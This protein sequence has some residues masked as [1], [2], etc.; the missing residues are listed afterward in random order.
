MKNALAHMMVQ[1]DTVADEFDAAIGYRTTHPELVVAGAAGSAL[2][3]PYGSTD[4]SV[5][6]R[7]DLKS[8]PNGAY[9]VTVAI[10][11][12]GAGPTHDSIKGMTATTGAADSTYEI[13]DWAG[14]VAAALNT[15]GQI[16]FEI[17]TKFFTQVAAQG[18][19]SAGDT[20]A[21][22][23][24]AMG[25][26]NKTNAGTGNSEFL[27]CSTGSGKLCRQ[28]HQG[29][30][31][32]RSFLGFHSYTMPA[33]YAF[34]RLHTFAKPA[35]G[36]STINVG[37]YTHGTLGRILFT[38]INGL[39]V[40]VSLRT[41]S[42]NPFEALTIGGWS[43]WFSTPQGTSRYL[44][45][46]YI[47]NLQVSTLAPTEPTAV[48][49]AGKDIA[50]IS[51]SIVSGL[52]TDQAYY[53]IGPEAAVWRAFERRRL[54]PNSLRIF[55]LSGGT[56]EARSGQ[57]TASGATTNAAGYAYG[58]TTITLASAGIGNI[59]TGDNVTFAGD[60]VI[61]SVTTGDTDVSNGGNIVIAAPGLLQAIPASATAIT[62]MGNDTKDAVRAAARALSPTCYVFNIGSND[63]GVGT[64]TA[65]FR[66]ACLDDICY[67]MGLDGTALGVADYSVTPGP[68]GVT[69]SV[70]FFT[71]ITDRGAG[72][73]W[74][75]ASRAKAATMRTLIAGLRADIAGAFPSLATL[76]DV[77]DTFGA[78]R[79][80]NDYTGKFDGSGTDT[81]PGHAGT[82]DIATVIA[83][84]ISSATA[85]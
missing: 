47:R 57:G 13:T 54:A 49:G 51:D 73:G 25:V 28:M 84:A 5:V 12:N 24:S 78:T 18:Y 38:A 76:V 81:H 10:R 43:N 34:P 60:N 27:R 39:T 26:S 3:L 67:L 14:G 29:S 63:V 16:S 20:L 8:N 50:I 4:A 58:A 31:S 80:T 7:H 66:L 37:W 68:P 32:G 6:F 19:G 1:A 56:A 11:G 82:H 41:D 75:P 74:T 85:A 55:Q 36:F 48:T 64:S 44:N 17:E 71:N 70:I 77:I 61:Y 53:D 59:V 42:G 35:N 40:Q 23:A 52:P 2:F 15:A 83:T 9:G 30:P 33:G 21:T 22:E 46:H 72:S 45:A 62:V 65:A 79:G 69:P